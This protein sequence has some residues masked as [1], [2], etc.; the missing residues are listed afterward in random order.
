M[1]QPLKYY[2]EDGTLVEFDKYII[3]H[4]GVIRNKKT[5][6][7]LKPRKK[8][9][10]NVCKVSDNSDNTRTIYIGRALAS[11]FAGPPDTLIHTA[12]H[13]DRDPTNDTI[14]NIRWANDREQNKNRIMPENLKTAVIVMKDGYEKTSKDWVECLKNEKNSFGREYT[15]IMIKH[16][17][18]KKQHGFSYKEYPDLPGEAWKEIIESK[19][20]KGRWE[21][22]NM[23]RVKYITKYAKN[24]LAEDRLCLS[25]GYPI[26]TFNK[27]KWYCHV[28]A[29]QTFFP[30]KYAAKKYDE[31]V[32]HEDD[33]KMDFRPHKLRLG[34]QSANM[35]DAHDNGKHDGK[36]SARMK[37]Y[38][39]INGVLEKEHVS[40]SEAVLY[41]K[42]IGFDKATQGGIHKALEAF[43]YGKISVR[44]ERTWQFE[45]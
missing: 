14:E 36:K 39:Y 13:V 30:E 37:C 42:S 3:D 40:Q 45:L 11:T 6:K 12:D 1:I 26:I 35:T 24:V 4:H 27:K 20:T 23:C 7:V 33:D 9:G 32:L 41:L 31:Y 21:I 8:D 25:G 28:L 29:F 38:S 18:Q 19:T 5:Q 22:S 2:Y 34:T 10:Y 15:D 17:A 44:Y 16:Y 43:T